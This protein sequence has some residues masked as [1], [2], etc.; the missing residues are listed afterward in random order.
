VAWLAYP[1]TTGIWSM[2]N[3]LTDP[4][5]DPPGFESRYTETSIRLP[6]T[7]WCY[8]PYGMEEKN[9]APLPEPSELPAI[10]N[11]FV[12]FGCLNEFSKISAGTLQRWGRLMRSVP[13]SRIHLLAPRGRCRDAVL[14][15]L[16][17][18]GIASERVEFIERKRRP[19]YLAEYQRIDLCLDTLP[20]NGHTTSLDA[21]W[22]GVP[23]LTQIGK[24]VV[25]RAGFSQ[26]T[27]L[28]LPDFTAE[29]DEQFIEL[30][31]R[32]A[33]DLSSLSEIRRT[34]RDRMSASPLMDG[35][36][37][38]RNMEASLRQMWHRWSQQ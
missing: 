25:G 1:G 9:S 22:M 36:R 23:V 18:F 32:W 35:K 27:N 14:E 12:T 13:N 34:L 4:H 38:A 37:F 33:S 28:Q 29:T 11:G 26:L 17:P 20:Y 7:F 3:R 15:Q 19:A 6:D 30:G 5:L 21:F 31:R 2:D 10:R 16:K 8:E 24:T